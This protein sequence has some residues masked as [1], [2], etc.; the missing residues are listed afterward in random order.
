MQLSK[1]TKEIEL[2][3]EVDEAFPCMEMPESAE[4]LFHQDQCRSCAEVRRYLDASRGVK[5]D[6]ALIR[7]IHQQ[8]YHLSPVAF[9]W[10][11]PSYLKFCLSS[12]SSQEEVYFLVYNLSPDQEFQEDTYRRLSALNA[13]QIRCLI[14]FLN[15]CSGNECWV[16]IRGDVDKAIKFLHTVKAE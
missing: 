8:L 3:K 14:H 4:L 9:R 1:M 12:V 5:A 10:I 11:L 2:L 6:D 13:A 16:E 15:W 7:F